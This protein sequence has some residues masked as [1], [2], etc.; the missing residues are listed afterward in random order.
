ME[1]VKSAGRICYLVALFQNLATPLYKAMLSASNSREQRAILGERQ[2]FPSVCG[3][4]KYVFPLDASVLSRL[5]FLPHRAAAAERRQ[6]EAE[7]AAAAAA[8][9][10]AAQA[11]QAAQSPNAMDTSPNAALNAL[12]SSGGP[13]SGAGKRKTREQETQELTMDS[14][15]PLSHLSRRDCRASCSRMRSRASER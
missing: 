14:A 13:A 11:A 12:L 1:A 9:A 7:E 15:C 3:R 10:A 4:R 8:A 6:R 5:R 2:P